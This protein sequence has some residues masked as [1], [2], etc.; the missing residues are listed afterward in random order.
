M[1][2]EHDRK[3]NFAT[4]VWASPNHRAFIVL[5]VYIEHNGEPFF[6]LLDFVEVPISHSGLNFATV[7][8]SI[9]KEF[10]IEHKILS[11]TCN[12]V[13]P[14]I[15][16]VNDLEKLVE[17]FPGEANLTCCFNHILSLTVKTVVQQFDVKKGKED[18]ALDEAKQALQ[19]LAAGSDLEDLAAQVEELRA[20]LNSEQASDSGEEDPDLEDG[21]EDE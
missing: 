2:Q 8:A 5:T 9:L 20:Q 18:E 19:E 21:W 15:V 13:S 7:F 12:N 11:V 14:N 1:L 17:D 6:L 16:M 10:G 4:N 3:L